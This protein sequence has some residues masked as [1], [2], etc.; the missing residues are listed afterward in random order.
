MCLGVIEFLAQLLLSGWLQ[1]VPSLPAES[2]PHKSRI[3]YSHEVMLAMKLVH[4][5]M[6]TGNLNNYVME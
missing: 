5:I 2:G 1:A 4:K 3:S 6:K